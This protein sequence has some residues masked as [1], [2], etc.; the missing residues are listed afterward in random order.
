MYTTGANVN[1]LVSLYNTNQ[2]CVSAVGARTKKGVNE[3]RQA[4]DCSCLDSDD[5]L[6]HCRRH[7]KAMRQDKRKGPET[8]QNMQSSVMSQCPINQSSHSAH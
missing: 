5:E 7:N 8:L 1:R 3:G 4:A 6:Q 2:S